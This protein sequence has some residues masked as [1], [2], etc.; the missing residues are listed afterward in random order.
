VQ[1]EQQILLAK[2]L[3]KE[4]E[5]FEQ[6]KAQLVETRAGEA[7]ARD[8]ERRERATLMDQVRRLENNVM[9]LQHRR[10]TATSSDGGTPTPS[11]ASAAAP[12]TPLSEQTTPGLW[13]GASDAPSTTPSRRFHEA[14][15]GWT[16]YG[17]PSNSIPTL[18][19]T[20][21]DRNL[22][23]SWRSAAS[24]SVGPASRPK[25]GKGLSFF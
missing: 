20:I 23:A 16:N 15:R 6:E 11:S 24:A 14:P 9:Q 22:G 5:L 7:R 17:T 19:Q 3:A 10:N 1:K 2:N 13:P 8:G 12:P 25:A 18:A 21:V 4:K